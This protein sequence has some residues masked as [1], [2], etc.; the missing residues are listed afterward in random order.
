MYIVIR[1]VHLLV[2]S[3]S[4]PFL[5][6]YVASSV[7]M[8]HPSWFTMKPA[9]HEHEMSVMPGRTD[10]RQVAREVMDGNESIRG[11][12]TNIRPRPGGVALRVVLPGTVHD[13]DYDR[14]SGNVKI[15]TS[16]AGF[17]GMLNRLHH[18]AG[19][20]HETT[21]MNGWGAAVA[22]VSAGLLLLGATGIYMWFTRRPERVIGAVLLAINL[23]VALTL[24]LTLRREGPA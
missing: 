3:F 11:E 21:A 19:V 22:I 14:L 18:A 20:R 6:M 10:A 23:V 12:L 15:R 2:A 13:A 9:V 1:N 8:S 7:Q 5:L 17:M 24:L 16:V 4:L